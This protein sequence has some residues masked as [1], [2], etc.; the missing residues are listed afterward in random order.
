V[1]FSDN[2]CPNIIYL[3]VKNSAI[4]GEQEKSTLG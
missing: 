1:A 3:H 4:E 2:F